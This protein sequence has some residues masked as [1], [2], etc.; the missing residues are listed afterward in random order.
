MLTVITRARALSNNYL[1]L[2]LLLA[3]PTRAVLGDKRLKKYVD[4]TDNDRHDVNTRWRVLSAE[5]TTGVVVDWSSR[6]SG[7]RQHARTARRSRSP[8]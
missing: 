6:R 7:A 2:L 4:E 1:F 5:P 3:P 8:S